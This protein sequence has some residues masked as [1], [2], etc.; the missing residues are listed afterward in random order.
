MVM[1]LLRFVL[2][3]Q[4]LAAL[5]FI[6]LKQAAGY[7]ELLDFVGALVGGHGLEI[8]HVTNHWIFEGD[9]VRTQHRARLTGDGERRANIS[10]S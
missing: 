7:D 3:I 1:P 9:A 6:L 2:H 10:R 8:V 5:Y 4:N